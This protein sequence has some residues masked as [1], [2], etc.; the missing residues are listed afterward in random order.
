[1]F[2][3]AVLSQQLT[4]NDMNTYEN[5]WTNPQSTFS[6]R[7][8][9]STSSQMPDQISSSNPA[10]AELMM[11]HS[12]VKEL[13]L[14]TCPTEYDDQFPGYGHSQ[15]PGVCSRPVVGRPYY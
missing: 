1:M 5:D 11:L 10:P 7:P 12:L 9:L 8:S 4:Q 6:A 3:E 15:D 13:Y 2:D 14:R